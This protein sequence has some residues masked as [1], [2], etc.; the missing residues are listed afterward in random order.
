MQD[1]WAAYL[2]AFVLG[3]THAL[4]VDH[5]VA[6][7][8]FFGGRPRLHPAIMFGVRWGMGHAGVVLVVGTLLAWSGFRLPEQTSTWAEAGVG[9]MLVLLG[10]WA[11]RNAYRLH[12][13]DPASHAPGHDHAH[14]HAHDPKTH[15]HH[16]RKDSGRRHRHLSTAIGAVHGLAGTAPV[17]ALI[18]VTL[19]DDV[20]PAVGYLLA[21][22]IGTVLAMA[23]YA[24]A[25]VLAVGRAATNVTVARGLAYLTAA[26][27]LAIGGVWLG[28]AAGVV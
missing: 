11:L 17:V 3:A 24:A 22:G 14:L 2:A 27:S 19:I 1:L 18:P 9:L 26:A 13:H 8:T 16:H 15:P 5:M 12:I 25:A 10:A 28:R 21:F 7:T 4:E 6:V 20:L 23:F